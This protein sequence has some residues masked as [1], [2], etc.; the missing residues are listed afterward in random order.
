ML[1]VIVAVGIMS[2]FI[3]FAHGQVRQVDWIDPISWHYAFD[4]IQRQ[5]FDHSVLFAILSAA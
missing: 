3:A 4:V 1:S 5:Y 2:P